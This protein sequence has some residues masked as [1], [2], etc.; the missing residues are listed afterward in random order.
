MWTYS[1]G[2]G[3]GRIAVHYLVNGFTGTAQVLGGTQNIPDRAGENGTVG[4]FDV[5]NPQQV[6]LYA[7]HSWHFQP[8]DATFALYNIVLSGTTAV[9]EPGA[10]KVTAANDFVIDAASTVTCRA[11]EGLIHL[12]AAN[13]LTLA[14]GSS[15]L[16]DLKGYPIDQ[17]PGASTGTGGAGYGGRGGI[18]N[19][20]NR[21]LWMQRQGSR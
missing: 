1:G 18:G 17:G 20:G 13:N 6:R 16:A 11:G 19:G 10:N 7:G 9:V 2:G 15:I 14:A 3:G 4:F 5:S 21:H 8:L 12:F